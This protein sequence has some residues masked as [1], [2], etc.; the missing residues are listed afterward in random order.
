M[1]GFTPG[2][3]A[4]GCRTPSLSSGFAMAP[5]ATPAQLQ[6][7]TVRD[8]D[9]CVAAGA[10]SGKTFVLVERFVGLVRDGIDPDRILTITFTEKAATEMAERIGKALEKQGRPDARRAVEGAWIS[11]IHGFCARLLRERAV[12]AG[13]DPAFAV[14][15]DVPAARVRRAAFLEAQRLFRA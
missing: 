5:D 3:P 8:V 12:E 1:A 4:P 10:G 6:A 7:I 14:L 15:T 13:V 11:T 9:V 2:H